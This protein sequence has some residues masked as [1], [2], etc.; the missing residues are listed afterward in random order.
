MR[1]IT[2][3]VNYNAT[4]GILSPNGNDNGNNNV[5][6]STN[7]ASDD[8]LPYPD[9]NDSEPRISPTRTFMN[10]TSADE[11]ISAGLVEEINRTGGVPVASGNGPNG[12][13]GANNTKVSGV[14]SGSGTAKSAAD[15]GIYD[16]LTNPNYYTGAMK[17]VFEQDLPKKREKVQQIKNQLHS[18][19]FMYN[20][21]SVS[22][23]TTNLIRKRHDT[24][25]IMDPPIHSRVSSGASDVYE[26]DMEETLGFTDVHSRTNSIGR[27]GIDLKPST[28]PLDDEDHGD[29][30]DVFG[31]NDVY[32]TAG[33]M[34]MNIAN[35]P[36]ISTDPNSGGDPN[37]NTGPSNNPISPENVFARLSASH[38]LSTK[39][40]SQKDAAAGGI[41]GGL[42][43]S[44]EG[45]GVPPRPKPSGSG[46]GQT[47]VVST[48]PPKNKRSTSID[49]N[50]ASALTGKK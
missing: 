8:L 39:Y 46:S 41:G 17:K 12:A 32:P 7:I 50:Y 49:K 30:K 36:A 43:N 5:A 1:I 48:N 44:S 24:D 38:T 15:N 31:L 29:W 34:H 13:N 28:E 40:K 19:S 11:E 23:D 26:P 27:T 37:P 42:S 20:Q 16:R 2:R 18:I 14:G 9:T 22:D 45:L 21:P 10:A 25:D 6:N 3:V 35:K 47:H 33:S 4:S